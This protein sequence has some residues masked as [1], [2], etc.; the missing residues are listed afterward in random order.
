MEISD[1]AVDAAVKGAHPLIFEWLTLPYGASVR[2]YPNHDDLRAAD[3]AAEKA[4]NE[5]LRA[6]F[7]AG[8][9]AAAP[10]LGATK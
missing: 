9:E 3:A 4:N 1:E 8:L 5:L 2:D 10:Y 6:I 7:R